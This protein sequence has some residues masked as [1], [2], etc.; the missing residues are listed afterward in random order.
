MAAYPTSFTKLIGGKR[1]DSYHFIHIDSRSSL[2][3]LTGDEMFFATTEAGAPT[4]PSRWP[5]LAVY[6]DCRHRS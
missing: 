2:A 6:G 5:E 1:Y 3:Q 4:Y